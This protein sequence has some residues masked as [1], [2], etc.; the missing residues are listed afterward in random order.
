[1]GTCEVEGVYFMIFAL[2]RQ[3]EIGPGLESRS[4]LLEGKVMSIPN[5]EKFLI[6]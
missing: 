3:F 2:V 6:I 5:L 4:L 1:M